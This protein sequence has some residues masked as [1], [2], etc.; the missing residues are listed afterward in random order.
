V[1]P[2]LASLAA[3]ALYPA[4]HAEPPGKKKKKKKKGRKGNNGRTAM[5]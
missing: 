4:V 3:A 2:S 1:H 5:G